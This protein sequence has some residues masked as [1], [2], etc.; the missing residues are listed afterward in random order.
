MTIYIY[1][2]LTTRDDFAFIRDVKFRS[3]RTLSSYPNPAVYICYKLKD[4]EASQVERGLNACVV[5][6]RVL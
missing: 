2:N 3:K 4:I 5:I 1:Y 6:R